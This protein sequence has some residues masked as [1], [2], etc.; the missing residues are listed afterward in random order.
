MKPALFVSP[1]ETRTIHYRPDSEKCTNTDGKITL[2]NFSSSSR[3]RILELTAFLQEP[4][5]NGFHIAVETDESDNKPLCLE[6]KDHFSIFIS[7]CKDKLNQRWLVKN[8]D[9]SKNTSFY[10]LQ[11]AYTKGCIA[12]DE[13]D[14]AVRQ[15]LCDDFKGIGIKSSKFEMRNQSSNVPRF[16][17]PESYEI[18]VMHDPNDT[19][20]DYQMLIKR[21]LVIH[22]VSVVVLL[23][24]VIFLYRWH[25][26]LFYKKKFFM[27][28]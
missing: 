9:V 15:V 7:Q 3:N 16:E 22:C 8:D 20:R 14:N 28:S 23:I 18:I 13:V 17:L 5:C 27:K 21:S 24:V 25:T 11:N 2:D 10:R 1:S 19:E 12:M 6:A 4:V 26:Y